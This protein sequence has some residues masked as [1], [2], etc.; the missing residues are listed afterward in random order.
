MSSTMA[1]WMQISNKLI[2]KYSKRGPRHRCGRRIDADRLNDHGEKCKKIIW[3][4]FHEN[5]NHFLV[6]DIVS[7][8]LLARM[9]PLPL[10]PKHINAIRNRLNERRGMTENANRIS[11]TCNRVHAH[12][13]YH[14]VVFSRRIVREAYDRWT[15]QLFSP[16]QSANRVS[17]GVSVQIYAAL[18]F[19]DYRARIFQNWAK[20]KHP[21]KHTHTKSVQRKRN[22][23][24]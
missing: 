8:V 11:G 15:I 22:K 2:L 4:C 23:S 6:V 1:F 3:K 9:K 13:F 17:D 16:R 7:Y 5:W 14:D 19:V 21:H 18:E 20:H 10:H 12:R 24:F